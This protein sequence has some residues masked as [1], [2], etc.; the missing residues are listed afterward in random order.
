MVIKKETNINVRRKLYINYA[1]QDYLSNKGDD[2]DLIRFKQ[3][4]VREVG[5]VVSQSRS[6][7]QV[8]S[9]L[10]RVLE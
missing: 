8:L 3:V 2:L 7:L 1:C 6:A 4:I 9:D 5:I 10:D